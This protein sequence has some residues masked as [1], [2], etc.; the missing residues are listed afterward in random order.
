M[1]FLSLCGIGE[2][3]QARMRRMPQE[4]A[5]QEHRKPEKGQKTGKF[6]RIRPFHRHTRHCTQALHTPHNRTTGNG[7]ICKKCPF[8]RSAGQ[9]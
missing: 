8:H 1:S 6:G 5:G 3:L 4:A 9:E 2:V 7:A